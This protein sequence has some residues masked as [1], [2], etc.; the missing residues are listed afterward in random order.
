MQFEHLDPEIEATIRN[1]I[2]ELACLSRVKYAFYLEDDSKIRAKEK[3]AP[4]H[5]GHGPYCPITALAEEKTG[6]VFHLTEYLEAAATID[7]PAYIASMIARAADNR[8][9]DAQH[10]IRPHLLAAVGLS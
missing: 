6:K 7:I 2:R 1:F 8:K 4:H 5:Y 9:R 10:P 3:C